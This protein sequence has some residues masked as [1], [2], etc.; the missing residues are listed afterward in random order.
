MADR[1][2]EERDRAWRERDWRRSEAY[3]RGGEERSWSDPDEDDRAHEEPAEHYG[4]GYRESGDDYGGGRAGGAYGRGAG[5][6]QAY[7]AGRVQARYGGA[8][9]PFGP[10]YGGRGYGGEAA[11]G[12]YGQ[13]RYGGMEGSEE[14]GYRYED[15]Y[16]YDR[17]RQS[18]RA[19]EAEG[20]GYGRGAAQP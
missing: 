5:R 20:R 1:W 2:M 7:R 12:T 18:R 13:Q 9:R 8:S 19:W 14:R 15:D 17:D 11:R 6:S 4:S 16:G 10:D 3:G